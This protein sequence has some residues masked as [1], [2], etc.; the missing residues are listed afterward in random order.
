MGLDVAV[1]GLDQGACDGQ[2]YAAATVLVWVVALDAVEP[3]EDAWQVLRSDA[4][5]VVGDAES[6]SLPVVYGTERD[7]PALRGVPE[8][9]AE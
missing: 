1:V 4:F 5:T 3:F 9:V 8:G 6:H 7:F 2:A